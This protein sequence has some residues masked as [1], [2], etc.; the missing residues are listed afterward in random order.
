M[1]LDMVG[2]E[3]IARNIKC[4]ARKGR[5]INIAYLQ[6][7]K[8]EINFMTVMLK[9]LEVTGST[10]RVQPVGVKEQ[11]A[12]EL[13]ET[14]WP[15]IEK[16]QIKPVLHSTFK[17]DEAPQSHELMESSA[18]IGKIVLEIEN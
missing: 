4:L 8:V 13:Q 3:Y 5:L 7:S 2:G 1:I 17:M 10:L 12:K 11:I 6:G 14:V 16:G 9:Q 15:L 18:H